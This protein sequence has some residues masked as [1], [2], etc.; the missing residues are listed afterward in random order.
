MGSASTTIKHVIIN[1]TKQ[2]MHIFLCKC[3]GGE[4]IKVGISGDFLHTISA[5]KALSAC[6]ILLR[7]KQRKK[8]KTQFYPTFRSQNCTSRNHHRMS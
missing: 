3:K 5:I 6:D 2:N 1:R 8:H 4:T 7:I